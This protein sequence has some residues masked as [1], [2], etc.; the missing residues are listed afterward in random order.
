MRECHEFWLF[1]FILNYRPNPLMVICAPTMRSK[2]WPFSRANMFV[3][4]MNVT[5]LL[6]PRKLLSFKKPLPLSLMTKWMLATRSCKIWK[7]SGLNC[8]RSGSRL[9]KW[10]SSH[11]LVFNQENFEGTKQIRFKLNFWI[12]SILPRYK[13]NDYITFKGNIY[14]QS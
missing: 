7:E 14:L 10:K 13:V 2:S 8:L 12:I 9:M 6:R 3:L 11:G 5:M 4:R 1:I